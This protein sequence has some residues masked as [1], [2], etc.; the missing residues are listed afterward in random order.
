M[1]NCSIRHP[2]LTGTL[3]YS[4]S[5]VENLQLQSKQLYYQTLNYLYHDKK[6]LCYLISAQ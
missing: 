2:D 5:D 6:N 3:I 1:P 4:N